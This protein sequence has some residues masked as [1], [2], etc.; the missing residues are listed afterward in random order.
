MET[1]DPNDFEKIPLG[2]VV[3][4]VN[5][6]GAYAFELVGPDSHQLV[7]PA[8]P[9]FSSAEIAGEMV[10]LYWHSIGTGYSFQYI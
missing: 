5:P 4:L 7:I 6:Q 2:G 8:P 9:A 3:K 1:G 10:E